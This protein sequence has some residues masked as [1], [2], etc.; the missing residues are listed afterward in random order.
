[1]DELRRQEES[2]QQRLSKAK[3]GLAAAETEFA[4]LPPY[5]PPKDKM[6]RQLSFHCHRYLTMSVCY[7]TPISWTFFFLKRISFLV[8]I[9]ISISLIYLPYPGTTKCSNRGA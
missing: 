9:V 2:R 1:M 6:V 4:N 5:E 8:L 3:E 7:N